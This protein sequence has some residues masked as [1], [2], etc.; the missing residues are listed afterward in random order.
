MAAAMGGLA[1]RQ[2]AARRIVVLTDMLELG[3]ES[4][5]YHAELAAPI[6]AAGVDLVF[7]AGEMMSA[8][9]EVL[10]SARRGAHAASASELTGVIADALRPGDVV[11][12]KGSN[13]SKAGL[14]V[15]ALTAHFDK[16]AAGEGAAH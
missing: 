12:V 1:A 3:P 5:R 8:L 4:L 7:C 2:D 15:S 11:M 16:I 9:W 10:P 14:I 6:A 13:G